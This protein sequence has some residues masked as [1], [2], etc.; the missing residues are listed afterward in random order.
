MR[1]RTWLVLA[2]VAAT[3][4]CAPAA[5]AQEVVT[6]SSKVLSE[7][8]TVIEA[9]SLAAQAKVS[10]GPVTTQNMQPFGPQWGGGAHL[11]WR[12]PAPVDTPIRN[13]PHLTIW[14]NAPAAGEYTLVLYY[15]AA[16]DY[17]TFRVFLNGTPVKDI[18]GFAP[19]VGLRKIELVRS[20]LK[21]G[22][23]QLVFTVFSKEPASTNFLVGLDRFELRQVHAAA[24]TAA[25]AQLAR[26]VGRSTVR[27][28][29]PR[30]RAD[31]QQMIALPDLP[32]MSDDQ[33][34]YFFSGGGNTSSGKPGQAVMLRPS[35]PFV[36]GVGELL[37]TSCDFLWPNKDLGVFYGKGGPGPAGW[38][39]ANYLVTKPGIPHLVN[40]VVLG[41]DAGLREFRI[42]WREKDGP[43]TEQFIKAGPGFQN[44]TILFTPKSPDWYEIGL[45]ATTEGS[46]VFKRAEITM[47]K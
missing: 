43:E 2:W 34:M 45:E 25:T 6:G 32:P 26:A 4:A 16:P 3:L 42:T 15:T 28:S 19:A 41:T 37:L 44:L 20:T 14:L 24:E 11:F 36:P 18:S 29:D 38:I 23:Q 27:A 47:M 13:W 39:R 21:A 33:K 35:Q 22:P 8:G 46:F 9:E 17:G 30:Q 31:V 5:Q 1:S 7:P 40:F 12:P 10:A